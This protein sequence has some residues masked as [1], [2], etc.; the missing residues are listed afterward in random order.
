[1]SARAGTHSAVAA[2]LSANQRQLVRWGAE[3]CL[4]DRDAAFRILEGLRDGDGSLSASARSATRSR[5]GHPAG[6][7]DRWAAS[8]CGRKETCSCAL[9]AGGLG[10]ERDL[11]GIG[12]A[13]EED[14]LVAARFGEGGD[15][16]GDFLR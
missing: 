1:M 6:R 16:V 13:G 12:V 14:Q 8:G 3:R 15:R 4:E 10:D 2:S 7:A 5:V 9:Q 11:R